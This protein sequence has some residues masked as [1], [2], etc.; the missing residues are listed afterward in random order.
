MKKLAAA[1][2]LLTLAACGVDGEP[3]RPS[4]ATT[5]G[6]GS[7]GDVYGGT[8]VGATLG[9]VTVGTGLGL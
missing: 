3:V 8:S 5:V 1:L 7:G 4:M 9:N 6:V 2:A